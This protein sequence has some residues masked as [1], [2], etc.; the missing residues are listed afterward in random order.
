[1]NSSYINILTKIIEA[2]KS[3]GIKGKSQSLA[4]NE[5]FE[6]NVKNSDY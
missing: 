2:L 4:I 1:M 3:L 5:L 6:N